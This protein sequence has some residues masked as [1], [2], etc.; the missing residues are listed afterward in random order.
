MAPEKTATKNPGRIISPGLAS[1][2]MDILGLEPVTFGLQ[3]RSS[4]D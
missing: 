3:S 1:A 2:L 4:T